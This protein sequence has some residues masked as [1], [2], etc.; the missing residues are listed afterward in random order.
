MHFKRLIFGSFFLGTIL[1]NHQGYGQFSPYVAKI[2]EYRPAPGQFINSAYG[3]PWA[4]QSLVGGISGMVSLGGFGGYLV[5]G[6]DHSIENHP[7]NPY[8]V[9]FTIFG[10]A[11][12]YSSEP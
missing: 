2:L 3:C 10:N 12:V 8:G 5:V 6:F 11:N 7:D 4:S 9:D 1:W